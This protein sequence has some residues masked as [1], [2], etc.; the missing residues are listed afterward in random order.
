MARE[1]Q[2]TRGFVTLVD[3]WN[4]EWLNNYKWYAHQGYAVSTGLNVLGTLRMHRVILRLAYGDTRH[5]DH[6]NHNT[7]DNR[8]DNLRVCNHME[9]QRNQKAR[10][11]TSRFK[12]VHWAKDRCR[13]RA[14]IRFEKRLKAL[15]YY[16]NEEDAARA[17][18][19]A[20]LRHFGEFAATNE[21]L[22]LFPT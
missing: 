13:W 5:V 11:G 12:G 14:Q 22:G 21:S 16:F 3:D 15:G 2:L 6:T 9:N 8:E 7:L 20:A 10:A 17:Y 19:E 1:I 18:D 4:Y